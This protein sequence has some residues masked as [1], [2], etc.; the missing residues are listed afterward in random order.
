VP[1]FFPVVGNRALRDRCPTVHIL[2]AAKI[3]IVDTD[4]VSEIQL[5]ATAWPVID[6]AASAISY[7]FRY[8]ETW[9]DLGGLASQLGADDGCRFDP[10]ATSCI[11]RYRHP[12]LLDGGRS[13]NGA[14]L[15][16]S[17]TRYFLP[18]C[19]HL[20]GSARHV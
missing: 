15:A 13:D 6:I 4:S 11:R 19:L 14:L 7:P 9:I 16:S 17:V 8:S 18:P 5:D 2:G 1:A 3:T 20:V 10:S 12:M